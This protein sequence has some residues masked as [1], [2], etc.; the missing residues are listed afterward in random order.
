MTF[1][2]VFFQW[3]V[4]GALALAAMGAVCLVI[5]FAAEAVRKK[6]W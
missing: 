1:S 3:L 6:L 4:H 5:L 2:P